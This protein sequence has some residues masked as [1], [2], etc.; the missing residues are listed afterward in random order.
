LSRISHQ[1]ND[2]GQLIKE[3][4]VRELSEFWFP[5]EFRD[6]IPPEQR[7][8]ALEQIRARMG[9][10]MANN[11]ERSYVYNE[12]GHM[13]ERYLKIG[14]DVQSM[15]CKYNEQGDTSEMVVGMNPGAQSA[16]S[17]EAYIELRHRY[18][19]DEHGN[20]IEQ[21]SLSHLRGQEEV[22]TS[23]VRRQVSYY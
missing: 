3:V 4:L 8:S 18:K 1:Y 17:S 6:Q 9:T 16:H 21:T 10:Q 12:V 19:Y 2:N 11:A 23:C 22:N 15:T 5:K 14:D 20:W 7:E 13:A